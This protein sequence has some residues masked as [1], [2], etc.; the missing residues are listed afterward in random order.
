M[1]KRER[2]EAQINNIRNIKDMTID[3]AYIKKKIWSFEQPNANKLEN[4]DKIDKS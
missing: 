4:L 3:A 2:E 1:K